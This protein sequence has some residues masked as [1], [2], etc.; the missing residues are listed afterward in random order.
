MKTK[1]GRA[2]LSYNIVDD[3]IR[4]KSSQGRTQ[5]NIQ[6]SSLPVSILI[7]S[8]HFSKQKQ[9]I[10]D[11]IC[12]SQEGSPI[13]LLPSVLHSSFTKVPCP[14]FCSHMIPYK[15]LYRQHASLFPPKIYKFSTASNGLLSKHCNQVCGK[16][17]RKS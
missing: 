10:A 11:N 5:M 17:S 4:H 13:S 3:D 8:S 9:V 15:A 2:W 14:W 6:I 1:K 16:L 7:F 12:P